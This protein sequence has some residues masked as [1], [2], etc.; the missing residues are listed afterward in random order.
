[1]NPCVKRTWAQVGQT[2][3]VQYRNRHHK[4]VSVIGAIATGPGDALSVYTDWHPGCYVRSEEAL[5]FVHRLLQEIDGPVALVWDNL[6]AHKGPA[7]RQLLAD[8][9]RLSIHYLPPY[10]PDLNPVEMLWCLTKHHRM[11][12]HAIDNLDTLE[13]EARRHVTAVAAEHHLLAACFA[14]AGLPLALSPP[15]AE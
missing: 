12:N 13:H 10:A 5:A 14:N 3:V 7:L 15:S 1:M 6:S 8:E 9:P 4:K 2:P 11:A